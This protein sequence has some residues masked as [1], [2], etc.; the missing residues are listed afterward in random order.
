[1]ETEPIVQPTSMFGSIGEALYTQNCV[2]CHGTDGQ[3]VPNLASSMATSQLVS[4]HD[5]MGLVLF[6]TNAQPPVN[7]EDG[8]PHPYRGGYPQLTDEQLRAII[9]YIYS[10]DF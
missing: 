1:M 6:L 7:P 10:L 8:F 2:G 9:A 3:G 4:D 5:G